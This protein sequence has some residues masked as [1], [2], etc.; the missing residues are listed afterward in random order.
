MAGI[1]ARG[2]YITPAPPEAA[3]LVASSIEMEEKDSEAATLAFLGQGI[4]IGI[5][6]TPEGL[7]G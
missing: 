2:G 3:T 6:M 5:L 4:G 7:G 1:D